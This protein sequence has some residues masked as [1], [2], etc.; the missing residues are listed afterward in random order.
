MQGGGVVEQ[1]LL[2]EAAKVQMRFFQKEV[3]TG[4]LEGHVDFESKTVFGVV[5]RQGHFL[6]V[7]ESG[8]YIINGALWQS[9]QS[10][11]GFGVPNGL[12][13]V[14]HSEP[15]RQIVVVRLWRVIS[16]N[17]LRAH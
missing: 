3:R 17:L 11:I 15:D 16:E 12:V 13:N 2:R 9:V 6:F 5:V 10:C 14:R 7:E 8:S 1:L 4:W